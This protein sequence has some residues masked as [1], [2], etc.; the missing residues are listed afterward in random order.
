MGSLRLGV[1]RGPEEWGNAS[2]EG[3]CKTRA[4]GMPCASSKFLLYAVPWSFGYHCVTIT[5]YARLLLLH[6]CPIPGF[7]V[8]T[9]P[10]LDRKPKL[11]DFTLNL[12]QTIVP[13]IS[14]PGSSRWH[15]DDIKGMKWPSASP[16]PRSG[17][18]LIHLSLYREKHCRPLDV[19][20]A[21]GSP[22]H[23]I[24]ITLTDKLH[25]SCY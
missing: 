25:D 10:T 13:R 8:A 17:F 1:T 4:Q 5:D 22:H 20:N 14:F 16:Y 11:L 15:G 23:F 7:K 6:R 12:M 3:D 21:V 9:L 18:A 19:H 2:N 24:W